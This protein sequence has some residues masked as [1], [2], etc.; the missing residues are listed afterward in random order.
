MGGAAAANLRGQGWT[1]G[2]Y[3]GRGSYEMHPPYAGAPTGQFTPEQ[4]TQMMPQVRRD[5]GYPESPGSEEEPGVGW[6][7]E[8]A[9]K[10]IMDLT[11]NPPRPKQPSVAQRAQA[12][13]DY[14]LAD[15]LADARAQLRDMGE[16]SS[17]GSADRF[18][19]RVRGGKGQRFSVVDTTTG[20]EVRG[21]TARGGAENQAAALNKKHREGTL[22][23]FPNG[24]Y[25]P[26]QRRGNLGD[27]G[28]R[29]EQY[30]ESAQR[31][32]AMAAELR[33]QG[34][35]EHA[36][37]YD[38]MAERADASAAR[39][40]A[41]SV[42]VEPVRDPGEDM[43]DLFN[44]GMASPGS[45]LPPRLAWV[46]RRTAELFGKQDGYGAIAPALP[47]PLALLADGRTATD[48]AHT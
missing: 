15:D 21:S 22:R 6:G 1:Q 11:K 38:A 30:L 5:L 39:E 31:H 9:R 8:R 20:K 3:M 10:G 14:G 19:V 25:S 48:H 43:A 2:R 18:V 45:G 35:E 26:G 28:T 13:V 41:K 7:S 47:H 27:R 42:P 33:G 32:R 37:D 29:A 46:E 34:N 36:Q 17:P 24:M 16:L 12:L 44:R 23:E 4:V 40:V